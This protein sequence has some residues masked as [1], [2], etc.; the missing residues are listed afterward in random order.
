MWAFFIS[1]RQTQMET[2]IRRLRFEIEQ[3]KNDAI[4]RGVLL[5]EI[6][7]EVKGNDDRPVRH[8]SAAPE[9]Q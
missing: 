4:A 2:D 5:N 9:A 3:M 7:Q 8:T 1:R 6:Y